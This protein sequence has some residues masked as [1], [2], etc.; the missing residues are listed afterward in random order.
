MKQNDIDLLIIKDNQIVVNK[1]ELFKLPSFST[2]VKK[3][4]ITDKDPFGNRKDILWKELMY[5]HIVASPYSLYVDLKLE[6]RKLKAFKVAKLPENWI[7]SKII[8]EC[9]E[10]YN[11]YI[12]L[13]SVHNSYLNASRALYSTGE[14][15]KYFNGLR[16]FYREELIALKE[17]L[18]SAN[19]EDELN[20]IKNKISISTNNLLDLNN[21]IIKLTDSVNKQYEN[22]ETLYDKIQKEKQE[23]KNLYGGGR[24]SKREI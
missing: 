11:K 12:E 2:L 6:N 21:A 4:K 22:M 16:D 23:S 13:S 9:I 24:I 10:E 17:R 15:I 20:D 18:E 5:I 14:D 3:V 19:N 8:K 1:I 7:E